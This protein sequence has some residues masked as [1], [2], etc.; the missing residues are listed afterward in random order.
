[1]FRSWLLRTQTRSRGFDHS[2]QYFATVS[3]SARPFICIAP[4]PQQAMATRSGNANFA[5]ITYG[6]PGPIEAR[7]PESDP[8][9]PRRNL[10]S[11]AYQLAVEPESAEMMQLSARRFEASQ[12]TR[13]A[14]IGWAPFI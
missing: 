3:N 13:C 4:S 5:A 2:F 12:H 8:I 7:L 9:I 11:R 6:T 1:M 14:W 10:R